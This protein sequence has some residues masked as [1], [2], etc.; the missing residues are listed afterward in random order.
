MLSCKSH[1]TTGELAAHFGVA[2]WQVRRAVD[3]LDSPILRAGLYR[4][5]PRDLLPAVEA[6]LGRK[7]YLRQEASRANP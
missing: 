7:G 3:A 4:L 2:V 6:A 5:V 1:L